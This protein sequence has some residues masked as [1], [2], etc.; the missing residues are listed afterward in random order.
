MSRTFLETVL[1]YRELSP[2]SRSVPYI[3]F[4]LVPQAIL[5]KKLSKA[6]E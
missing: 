1:L 5:Y 6:P 2:V 3:N 4:L